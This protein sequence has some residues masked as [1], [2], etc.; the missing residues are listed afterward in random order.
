MNTDTGQIKPWN[1]ITPE[2][3]KSGKW[4]PLA[5]SMVAAFAGM[6]PDD[7]VRTYRRM[8]SNHEAAS[9]TARRKKNKAQRLA[10][11]RNR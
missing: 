11:R 2:E 5:M 9:K 4:A 8:N 10:R 6:A 1:E 3:K 7:R